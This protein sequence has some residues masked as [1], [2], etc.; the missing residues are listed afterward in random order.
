M[1]EIIRGVNYSF[2]EPLVLDEGDCLTIEIAIGPYGPLTAAVLVNGKTP[3][4]LSFSAEFDTQE[5]TDE[6]A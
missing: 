2:Y 1:P 5:N 6:P 3:E 4:Q